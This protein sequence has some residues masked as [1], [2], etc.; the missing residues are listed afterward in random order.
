MGPRELKRAV[1]DAGLHVE[2]FNVFLFGGNQVCVAT[3]PARA[4][5]ATDTNAASASVAA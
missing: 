2:K 3:A 4:I 1:E 5:P